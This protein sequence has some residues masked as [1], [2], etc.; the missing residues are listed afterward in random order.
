ML[1]VKGTGQVTSQPAGD[2][3]V[4]VG[5]AA[6]LLNL[7]DSASVITK[8]LLEVGREAN[9]IG[10]VVQTGGVLTGT[11]HVAV[12]G[13]DANSVGIYSISG[14]S[15]SLAFSYGTTQS[16]GGLG[17][18]MIAQSGGT[19][20]ITGNAWATVGSGSNGYGVLDLSGGS[21]TVGNGGSADLL[22]LGGNGGT[23][24]LNVRGGLLTITVPG[25]SYRG[26]DVGTGTGGAL[27]IV[28][29]TGG[30]LSTP[31]LGSQG[32]ASATAI[33]NFNGGTLQARSSMALVSGMDAIYV[34]G[35]GAFIDSNGYNVTF[36][37][38]LLAAS[39]TG[40]AGI[41]VAAGGSGYST[42]PVV[43][44]TGG[45][46]VGATAVAIVTSGTIS[47]FTVVNPGTG[48][49]A[50][51]I[52]AITVAGG[53]NNVV[54]GTA[55][56]IVFAANDTTGG[57]TKSGSG[58]LTLTSANTYNGGTTVNG[59]TLQLGNAGALGSSSGAL[60]V[61][62]GTLDLHAYSVQVGTLSGSA[63]LIT[64]TTGTATL[65]TCASGTSAYN[66]N[67]TNGAGAVVL[68]QTGSGTLILGGSLTMAGLNANG[69][70]TQI[71]QSGSIGALNIATGAT[72]SMMAHSGSTYN[73]LDISSLT[74]SGATSSLDLNNNAM[75]LSA[76][77][78]AENA[79]NLMAVKAAVNAAS[80]GL[81]WNGLG[82]GSTTAFNEAQPGKTQALAVMVY[83]N[84]VIRQG[85]FEGV[86]GLGY[87]DGGNNPVGF[88]QVLVKLTYLGDFNADG[89]IDAS[90]YT[91]LDGYALSANALGDLNGDGS[92]N[93]TDYTW[94][95]GSA[96]NQ[97]F[98]VLT[99]REGGNSGGSSPEVPAGVTVSSPE[100][101]PEPGTLGM[102]LAGASVLLGL[103]RKAKR[104]VR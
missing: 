100:A 46:G 53:G 104:S 25:S 85:S 57:L 49:Q 102:L 13:R 31:S 1:T 30:T 86:S 28:N 60:T 12:L 19:L 37:Q 91:W 75:I 18:G 43:Q 87:F 52:V 29:L 48:Y 74:L 33:L 41:S 4:G 64:T 69:G 99:A 11:S 21:L 55:G 20:N 95:D 34:Y 98:G 73:V 80:N 62:N 59:G 35:G 47:G 32:G 56:T 22:G 89:V 81:Q 79:T 51:D 90:D 82:I 24:V 50:G 27:G 2:F 103:R 8:G 67:I 96:L 61:N 65:T 26:I 92:V 16:I 78:T 63:G 93:A 45:S 14:G 44:I 10:T 6:G 40:I 7:Q 15:A 71:Q 54:S 39:G 58:N 101:V 68:T 88:N 3:G 36:D 23:G 76:S 5:G 17:K 9:S 84:T 72:V 70:V 77:G 94:L 97:K 66:G 38:P 83:D 42:A